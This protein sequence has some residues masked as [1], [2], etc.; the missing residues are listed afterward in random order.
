MAHRYGTCIARH[1]NRSDDGLL[2]ALS[3]QYRGSVTETNPIYFCVFHAE[4]ML[5]HEMSVLQQTAGNH[6]LR[7][8]M[9][10][11]SSGKNAVQ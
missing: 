11:G 5:L 4:H 6:V 10:P 9:K 3:K 7:D 1:V 8:A 2:N